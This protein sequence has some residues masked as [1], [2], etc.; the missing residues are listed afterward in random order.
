MSRFPNSVRPDAIRLEFAALRKQIAAANAT[1]AANTRTVGLT[2]NIPRWIA[3]DVLFSDFTGTVAT[4]VDSAPITTLPPGTIWIGERIDVGTTFVSAGST[5]RMTIKVPVG[6]ASIGGTA[7]AP[8]VTAPDPLSQL[9]ADE[10]VTS[11][12]AGVCDVIIN[13]DSGIGDTANQLTQGAA[14]VHLFVSVPG[15]TSDTLPHA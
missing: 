7:K 14:T 8:D 6:G 9:V 13:L 4:T 1:A 10:F 11:N 3:L 2:D 12:P 15:S 5:W